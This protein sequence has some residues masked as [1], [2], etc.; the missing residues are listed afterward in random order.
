MK[1]IKFL[2]LGLL[3]TMIASCSSDEVALT[4]KEVTATI[5]GN[6]GSSL[7]TRAHDT[8]WDKNDQIGLF[9]FTS[10]YTP[11]GENTIY[12][13]TNNKP[14]YTVGGDN[15]LEFKPVSGEGIKFPSDG[16]SIYFKSY[17]PYSPNINAESPIFKVES[18]NQKNVESSRALDLLVTN[19]ATDVTDDDF[20]IGGKEGKMS[21]PQENVELKFKHIFSRLVL[22]IKPNTIESQLKVEDLEGLTASAEGMSATASYDVLNGGEVNVEE[23]EETSFDLYAEPNGQTV[24]AIICPSYKKDGVDR[25][26]T[27]TVTE[28]DGDVKTY[29]WNIDKDQTY[30]FKSGY[31]YSWAINLKG[32]G[33]AVGT[34]IGTIIDWG[35]DENFNPD[36]IDLEFDTNTPA[37]QTEEEQKQDEKIEP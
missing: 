23:N 36:E 25:I 4:K 7:K 30:D 19:T 9:T 6:I 33:L 24:T 11:D 15:S 26:I 28:K 16:S 34:L 18:W 2:S 5:T 37:Q 12:R 10:Q 1:A 29:K 13:E 20:N 35:T 21:E 17:Y 14:Y 27:F 3:A 22:T 32:D 8:T 31:S